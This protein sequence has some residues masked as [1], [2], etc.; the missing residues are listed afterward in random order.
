MILLARSTLRAKTRTLSANYQSS[1]GD[2]YFFHNGSISTQ[3]APLGHFVL[4]R[5]LGDALIEFLQGCRPDP[6]GSPDEC[7]VIGNRMKVH[8]TELPQDQAVAHQ[9]LRLSLAE[10]VKPSH[11]QHPREY[12]DWG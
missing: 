9:T 11:H 1:L 12:F 8:P 7:G 4:D 5:Q 2:V 3:L 10:V 6:L